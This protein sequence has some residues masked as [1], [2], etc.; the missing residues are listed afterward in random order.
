MTAE[1]FNNLSEQKK[2]ELIF[3]SNK[4]SEKV[5]EE[6][7]YQ[8]FQINNFFVE[9]KTSLEGKFKRSFTVY[10]L[11]ELPAEYV[12][13]VL[14]LPIVVLNGDRTAKDPKRNDA[15]MRKPGLQTS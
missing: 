10:C 6:A 8:L 4:I 7:N 15:T 5:D 3:D 13:E 14:S 12:G 11:K 2:V 1:I 9:A